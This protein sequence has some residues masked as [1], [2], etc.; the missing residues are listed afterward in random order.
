MRLQIVKH[1]KTINIKNQAKKR[2]LVR[3]KGK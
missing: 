2:Q 1:I 3:I